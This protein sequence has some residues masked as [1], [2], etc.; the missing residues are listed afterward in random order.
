MTF[1]ELGETSIC[2]TLP[3][4]LGWFLLAVLLTAK[5]ISD[6]ANDVSFLTCIGVVPVCCS[7]PESSTSSHFKPC[8]CVTT[9]ISISSVSKI[10]P[11]SICNS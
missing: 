7:V 1:L 11:C 10:G 9:P 8:P 2:P 6:I 4:A 5:I 3:S